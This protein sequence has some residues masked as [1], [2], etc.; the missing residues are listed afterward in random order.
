MIDLV[1]GFGVASA[2]TSPFPFLL[3]YLFTF[4]YCKGTKFG[5]YVVRIRHAPSLSFSFCLHSECFHSM[6]RQKISAIYLT[7]LGGM[8]FML[9]LRPRLASCCLWG[10]S[11]RRSVR[12][13]TPA[14]SAICCKDFAFMMVF[15][16]N[17]LKVRIIMSL[18]GQMG[19][20][21]Q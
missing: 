2:A 15:K 7:A 16:R 10:T 6:S 20:M 9:G 19:Q 21:G 12:T 3:F 4:S 18:L 14:L 17:R 1:I 13:L 11:Q 8:A 5:N